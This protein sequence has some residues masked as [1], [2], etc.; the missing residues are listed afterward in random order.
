MSFLQING[1]TKHGKK[2]LVLNH[3]SFTLPQFHRLAI[4]GETG[5]GKSTLLKIIAG[6]VQPDSGTVILDNERILGPTEKLVPGHSSIAYLSQHFELP[7]SLRVEQALAYA[8]TLSQENAS[9]IYQVCRI[10]HLLQR[11]T[12]ELSGG[13]RQ[14][15]AIARLLIA[16]PRLLLLDEPYSNLDMV[17]KSTLKEVIRDVG[18][19]LDISC[20][21]VSHDPDDT[22]PWADEIIIMKG[23]EVVQKGSPQDVYGHPVNEYAAGLLG[24]FSVVHSG[25]SQA[26]NRL[27]RPEGF[28]IVDSG[29][30]GLSGKVLN[31]SFMGSHFELDV[32]SQDQMIVIRSFKEYPIGETIFFNVKAQ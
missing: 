22:L 9:L 2:D 23:G 19:Q 15:I 21:L 20:I 26:E 17:R 16:S 13:E 28:E 32:D 12:D 30:S 29:T 4:A 8:N 6:L 18:Q 14:R 5:S 25:N 3:V 1:L 10:D 27:V 11:R 24:K 31:S 7:H